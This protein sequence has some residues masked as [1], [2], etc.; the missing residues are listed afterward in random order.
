MGEDVVP[1]FY[2]SSCEYDSF[3]AVR[4]CYRLK[5]L[6]GPRR[7]DYLA[8]RVEPPLAGDPV[9]YPNRQFEVLVINSRHWE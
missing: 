1:D 4:R 7:D 5:R 9:G 8:I 6:V 3:A 2:M